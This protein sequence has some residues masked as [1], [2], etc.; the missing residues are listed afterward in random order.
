MAC[1]SLCVLRHKLMSF[2]VCLQH[3]AVARTKRSKIKVVERCPFCYFVTYETC[4][5][6]MHV[7]AR[8]ARTLRQQGAFLVKRRM[9]WLARSGVRRLD[10]RRVE[11]HLEALGDDPSRAQVKLAVRRIL[12]EA[13]ILVGGEDSSPDTDYAAIKSE[14]EGLRSSFGDE[15]PD[16]SGRNWKK[17]RRRERNAARRS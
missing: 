10:R 17:I 11:R 4:R 8:H 9:W 5:L 6:T 2:P 13:M 12:L 15:F 3:D 1:V 16:V 7:E 14:Y